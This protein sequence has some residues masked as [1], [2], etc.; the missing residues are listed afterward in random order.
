L[1]SEEV[2]D[3][4][5]SVMAADACGSWQSIVNWGKRNKLDA[6]QEVAF[7]VLT[8]TYVLTFN[9]EAN[10]LDDQA[11]AEF[12]KNKN[13]LLELK[14]DRPTTSLCECLLQD[15]ELANVS[16]NIILYCFNCFR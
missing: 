14:T 2:A 13:R 6:E 16:N 12:I 15:L 11:A 7:E 8:A 4:I 3:E 5:D 10:N 9:D 1:N